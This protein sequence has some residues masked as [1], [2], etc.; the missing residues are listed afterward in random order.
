MKAGGSPKIEQ[1][2]PLYLKKPIS[3]R[4]VIDARASQ[5][6]PFR[7]RE[8]AAAIRRAK[9]QSKNDMAASSSTYFGSPQA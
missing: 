2:M 6:P 8:R 9:N 4:L 5:T 1:I 3:P 7:P